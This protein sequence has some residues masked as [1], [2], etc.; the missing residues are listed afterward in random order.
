MEKLI[1]NLFAT[2]TVYDL[3]LVE[4]IQREYGLLSLTSSRL[5]C[6]IVCCLATLR[7]VIY[8]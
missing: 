8:Y 3:A 7:L 2:K 6:L 4:K 5:A 1:E